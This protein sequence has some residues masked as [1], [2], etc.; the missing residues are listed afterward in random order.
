MIYNKNNKTNTDKD[1]DNSDTDND[2]NKS[3]INDD[4][5]YNKCSKSS[6]LKNWWSLIK[7]GIVFGNAITVMGGFFLGVGRHNFLNAQFSD[8]DKIIGVSSV[9]YGWLFFVTLLGISLV[10]A[11]GCVF[12]NYID[13]D[14][15]KL[16]QRTK[17]RVLAQGLISGKLAIIYAIVLGI[18]GIFLL[19]IYTNLLAVKLALIGLFV[20]VVVYSLW[21]KR[22]S[23]YGTIIGSI[24]GAMPPV[25]G[26]C[27]ISGVF[28]VGA[29][30]LFLMLSIWQIPHSF[31]IAIYRFKDYA[32]AGIPVLPVKR[33][34][35]VAKKHILVYVVIFSILSVM[36]SV[37][38]Y[39]GHVYLIIATI[40]GLYW[41][42][43]SYLGLK[44]SNSADF[45]SNIN[46]DSTNTGSINSSDI[47]TA[48]TSISDDNSKWAR[49]VFGFS[50]LAITV[51]SI[52]M[53]LNPVHY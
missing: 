46:C 5:N 24:S 42:R 19:Y 33:G 7:P 6:S 31:A 25:V 48:N 11:S 16:M 9:N 52:T 21:L 45:M 14:I 3:N 1:Y 35:E 27:A 12:N 29:V 20:Y 18:L 41:I 36:L 32:I 4:Y 49:K 43:L 38:G 22:N 2:C 39:T 28:D 10:I 37:F 26:Y 13:R 17:N 53:A 44:I 23:I 15:D 50:I 30:V 8:I 40:T 47:N 51:L 34:L